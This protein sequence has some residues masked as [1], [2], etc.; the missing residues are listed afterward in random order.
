M[1]WSRAFTVPAL[2]G[3]PPNTVALVPVLDMIDHAPGVEAAWHTGRDG[4]SDFT[5]VTLTPFAKVGGGRGGVG[6]GAHVLCA[7]PALQ[8]T[9]AAR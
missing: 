7:H 6:G 3:C 2:R 5:F 1:V 9:L 4:A 8:P